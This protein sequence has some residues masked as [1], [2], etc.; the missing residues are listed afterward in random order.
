MTDQLSLRLDPELPNLPATLRPMTARPADGPFDSADHVFEPAWGGERV[1]AFLDS[2]AVGTAAVRLVDS[3]GRDLTAM[4]PELG[5]LGQRVS[6]TSAVLDG[7]IVVVDRSGRGDPAALRRRLDGAPGAPVAYL[8]FD[9]LYFDGRPLLAEPL[10]RR[11]ERLGRILTPGDE[12]V[13]VPSIRGEGRALYQ[14]V[15]DQGIA[16]VMARDVR[17]PYLPGVRSGLWRFISRA[18]VAL[19]ATSGTGGSPDGGNTD[20]RAAPAG[21]GRNAPVLALIR[22]LPLD[23]PR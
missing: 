5:T 19:D 3:S 15:V 21:A 1:L 13:A 12:I 16:G 11:R 7:E 8:A 10:S 6:A 17:S 4:L 22:R 23:D 2:R 9:L 14:A 18:L 20:E